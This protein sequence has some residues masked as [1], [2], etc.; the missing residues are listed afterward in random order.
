MQKLNVVVKA[1]TMEAALGMSDA[2]Q[3][4][5][6]IL[7]V[8][9]VGTGDLDKGTYNLCNKNNA[10][11]LY[12][13]V[14]VAYDPDRDKENKGLTYWGTFQVRIHPTKEIIKQLKQY[15]RSLHRSTERLAYGAA[16]FENLESIVTTLTMLPRKGHSV[17]LMDLLNMEVP[18]ESDE[19]T[20]VIE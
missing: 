18:S 8:I 10:V 12:S 5:N 9:H 20:E 7:D 2:L 3:A 15:S 6:E 17:S 1:R 4:A 11:V 14:K 13:G 16:I 19:D